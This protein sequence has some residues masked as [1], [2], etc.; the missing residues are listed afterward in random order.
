MNQNSSLLAVVLIIAS[1]TRLIPHPPNFT[2]VIA[3]G[4]LSVACF[5][6]RSLQ[7]GFPLLLMLVT[8]L[9]LGFHRLMPVVYVSVIL[10]SLSGFLLKK[11]FSLIRVSTSSMLAASIFFITS[12]FGVWLYSS[13]YAKT[14]TGFLQCLSMAIPFFHNSLLSTIMFT[15]GIYVLNK[16]L[17]PKKQAIIKHD[18]APL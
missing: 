5:K 17:S 7:L 9:F 1:I 6:Q 13:M 18:H 8:D 10:A 11:H 16:F 4:I 14:L 12:N 2:P 15:S 3:I